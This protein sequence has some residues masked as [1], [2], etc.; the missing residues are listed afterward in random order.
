MIDCYEKGADVVHGVREDTKQLSFLKRTMAKW[1]YAIFKFLANVQTIPGAADFRLM[2][3]AVVRNLSEMRESHRYLRGM[4]PWLGFR[5]EVI[6]YEQP[7]RFSGKPKYSWRMSFRLARY[8]LF[9]FSTI[10]LDIISV[11]GF[12]MVGLAFIYL[13]YVIGTA[14]FGEAVTG[15]ASVI[16]MVLILGGVQLI[17][18]GVVAQYIGMIFE[19]VKQRPQYVLKQKRLAKKETK[20]MSE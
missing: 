16:A 10:P 17:S 4:V 11:L 14:L 15:W 19:E 2:S 1:Y 13:V 12:F 5:S 20:K 9:S 3:Q 18:I 7:S 6:H 8:G